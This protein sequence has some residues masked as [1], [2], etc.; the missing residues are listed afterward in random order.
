MR[1]Y[2]LMNTAGFEETHPGC[3]APAGSPSSPSG[4]TIVRHALVILATFALGLFALSELG[5]ALPVAWWLYLAVVVA[6]AVALL[7]PVALQQQLARLGAVV[8]IVVCVAA[9]YFVDW[10][11]RKPFLR[12]LDRVR[13]GMTEAEVRG[14][15]GRYMDGTGW[16]AIPGSLSN[17]PGTLNVLGSDAHY[18]AE[19][20]SSGQL[21][22]RDALVFRHSND[23]AFNSD[24]GVVSM[25]NGRVVHVEFCPD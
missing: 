16:P 8:A 24:W 5:M 12:D 3:G 7:R 4:R 9:L 22:I 13:V 1:V 6:F 2:Q 25:S 23:G 21:A 10:S 11:T 18:A 17:A 15:M 19:A 14:I 20:S